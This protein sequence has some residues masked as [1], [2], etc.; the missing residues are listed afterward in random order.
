MDQDKMRE[1]AAFADAEY[2]S[3]LGTTQISPRM[4]A[5]YEGPR[6]MWDWRQ[7]AARL[8]GDVRDKALLDYGCGQGEE[9]A[10][11]SR[12]GAR[13]TAI[14]ISEVGVRVGRERA[15]ANGLDIDFRVMSCVP[16]D[17][18]D[19]TF[20]LVHGLG[21]L[22]HIGLT[23]GLAEVYRVLRPGGMAVFLEPLGSSPMVEAIK[24]GLHRRYAIQRNLIPVTSGEE[25]LR[26]ADIRRVGTR[27]AS[28]RI[29]P[30][31][32]TYRARKLF[33]PSS[34]WDLALRLDHLLLT[35]LPPLQHFA[36]GAVINL[37][38]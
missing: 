36:G 23:E 33:L 13:V 24:R 31:R 37:R 21:I 26:L 12:L 5:K 10:Y 35:M 32:L 9:A 11:F 30:Y 16:T 19:A 1:E 14:D 15:T 20:E 28:C 22:H 3:M 18:P 38:K 6:Q 25:N 7:R 34:L 17:F 2:A 27:W 4:F 29:Y 8:L